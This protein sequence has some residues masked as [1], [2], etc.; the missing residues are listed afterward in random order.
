M[1]SMDGPGQEQQLRQRGRELTQQGKYAEA[2]VIAQQLVALTPRSYGAWSTLAWLYAQVGRHEEA[3]PALDKAIA[4]APQHMPFHFRKALALFH[5]ERYTEALAVFEQAHALDPAVPIQDYHAMTLLGLQRYDEALA[6]ANAILAQSERNSLAWFVR[7]QVYAEKRQ[8]DEA[9]SSLARSIELE[10]TYSKIAVLG[11]LYLYK[12][13]DYT[14]ATAI[15]ERLLAMAPDTAESWTFNGALLLAQRNYKDA[16]DSYARA[17]SRGKL[18]RRNEQTAWNNLGIAQLH[19]G[20]YGDAMV[21]FDHADALVANRVA[22][23]INRGYILSRLSRY[24]QALIYFDRASRINPVQ[25]ESH[26]N[27]AFALIHLERLDEAQAEIEAVLAHD[28]NNGYAW[29]ARGMLETRNG[30]HG[31]AMT[32]FTTATAQAP[33]YAPTYAEFARLLLAMGDTARACDEADHAA[34]LEPFDARAW[35]MKAQALRTAGRIEEANN[36]E[37]HGAALLADQQAQVDAYF[38]AQGHG[39]RKTE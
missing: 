1:E 26:T 17:F 5:L 18:S 11:Q 9:E 37:R 4:L 31:A 7:G 15:S 13:R 38:A 24:Q 8:Y 32:A 21:S 14:K 39:E 19:L 12:L 2:I 23:V 10:P 30:H 29:G 3:I 16:R 33:E 36:A 27:K 25:P 22:T 28:P 35:A 6:A 34:T 20:R